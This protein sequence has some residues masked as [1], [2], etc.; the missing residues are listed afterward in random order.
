LQDFKSME[1]RTKVGQMHDATVYVVDD[2]PAV[3]ESVQTALTGIKVRPYRSA[4]EFISDPP[5][6]NAACLIL[7]LQMPGMPGMKLIEWL[8]AQN[9]E[10]P[11]IVLSGHGNI[12][13][14][15]ESMKLG[16][17]EFLEKPAADGVL[18]SKVRQLLQSES[19]R[20]DERAKL[21]EI[22]DR[23]SRLTEREKELVELLAGGLSSKQIAA[24][25]GIALKT[26]ENHRS[27]VL[28]KTGA[29][30]VASLVR[31]TM[32]IAGRAASA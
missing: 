11:I 21:S 3:R 9:I 15:V 32:I 28:A 5:S 27:H 29:A 13:A 10:M 4:D 31:M 16:A 12:P 19:V 14:V 24:R 17:V 22:R 26:V 7:D 2:D 18:V 23:F 8:R 1:I 6:R 25:V 30:N 20:Y